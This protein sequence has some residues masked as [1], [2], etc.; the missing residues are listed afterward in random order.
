MHFNDYNLVAEVYDTYVSATYDYSFFLKR[1]KTGM[2][3]LE[4]TSGT[5]RLS[6]PLIKAG[7][8][9][10]CVDI[11]SGMINVLKRKLD[12]E[13]LQASV[14]C[15]DVQHLGFSEEFD[16]VLFPFQ[17][18]MELVG[19]EQQLNALRSA[20]NALVPSGSFYCTMH[21]PVIR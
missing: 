21:N 19:K 12:S 2:R 17:S 1:V 9:L 18:F 10:T 3:V 11:S 7:A 5:G 8:L 15:A 14:L 20:N 4:L 16:I 13:S 6:L